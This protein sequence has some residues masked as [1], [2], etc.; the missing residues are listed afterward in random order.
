MG[1]RCEDGSCDKSDS[2][3]MIQCAEE[4]RVSNS[5]EG[6]AE[7]VT[8]KLGFEASVRA[9]RKERRWSRERALY[10]QVFG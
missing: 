4:Y 8:F 1:D 9:G 7:K 10:I 5:R 6:F 3:S 2:P